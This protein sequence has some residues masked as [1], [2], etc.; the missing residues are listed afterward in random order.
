M[1]GNVT[2]QIKGLKSLEAALRELGDP[3]RIRSAGRS[4]LRKGAEPIVSTAKALVPLDQGDLKR[5]IKQAAGKV[6]RGGDQDILRQVVG[7]DRNEQPPEEIARASGSGTYRDPGVLGVA[8][9]KEFGAPETGQPAQPFMRP[10]FDANV[11]RATV[12]IRRELGAAIERQ[13]KIIAKKNRG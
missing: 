8:A 5:S 10:A 13:A 1:P 9:I 4:A 7:I 3:K 11:G 6:R 2:F 12:T